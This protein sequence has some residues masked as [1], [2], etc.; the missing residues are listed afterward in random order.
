[1][2]MYKIMSK[3][4]YKDLLFEPEIMTTFTENKSLKS[5]A[6]LTRQLTFN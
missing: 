6:N 5:A 2:P 4:K 3:L 1:M